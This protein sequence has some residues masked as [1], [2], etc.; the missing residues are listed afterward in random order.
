MTIVSINT[1]AQIVTSEDE[2][3]FFDEL[4]CVSNFIAAH[5]PAADATVFV[6]DHR[7]GE[8]IRAADAV[9]TRTRV[10]TPMSSGLLAHATESSRDA[11][12]AARGGAPVAAIDLLQ[13]RHDEVRP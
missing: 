12:P 13:P 9:F 3:L 8:W 6:A 7:T 1:A 5:P 4:G 11:D 2:P 10:Q